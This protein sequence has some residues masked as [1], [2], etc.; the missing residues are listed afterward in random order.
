MTDRV[1]AEAERRYGD[2]VL[3]LNVVEILWSGWEMD[4]KAILVRRPDG[5]PDAFVLDAVKVPG[6]E[7]LREMLR[8][9][10]IAYTRAAHATRHLLLQWEREEARDG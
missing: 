7:D 5:G 8:Q 2:G 6:D 1:Q 3:V 9:R 4:S 10:I